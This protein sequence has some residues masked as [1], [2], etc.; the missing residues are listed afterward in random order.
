MIVTSEPFTREKAPCGKVVDGTRHREDDDS[1]LIIN[2]TNYGCGCRQIRHEYHDGS[3]RIR[4]TH[5]NGRVLADE[6]SS[7]HQG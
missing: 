3:Y 1:G 4:T 6:H 7:D 5:H 2:D